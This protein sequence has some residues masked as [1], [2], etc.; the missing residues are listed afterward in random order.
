MR[1][2][3]PAHDELQA[4]IG[5]ALVDPSFCKD[6]LNGHRRERL[7]EYQLSSEEREAL[8]NVQAVDLTTF[9]R[10]VDRWISSRPE[11]AIAAVPVPSVPRSWT[12]TPAA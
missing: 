2:G 7:A 10:E 1:H 6:L 12:L 11:P 4:V 3:M 5:R 8:A 9:A